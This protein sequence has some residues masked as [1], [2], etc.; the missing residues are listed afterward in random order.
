VSFDFRLIH[1]SDLEKGLTNSRDLV[2]EFNRD[3]ERSNAYGL[4]SLGDWLGS[5]KCGTEAP[6]D[7]EVVDRIANLADIRVPFAQM[8]WRNEYAWFQLR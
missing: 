7:P 2:E 6:L 8:A 1:S 4:L 3:I 5:E